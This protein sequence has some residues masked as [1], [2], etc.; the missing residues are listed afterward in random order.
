MC[1]SG[2][3]DRDYLDDRNNRNGLTADRGGPR[4]LY[5]VQESATAKKGG[6]I[7]ICKRELNSVDGRV[8]FAKGF[9]LDTIIVG[10]AT[11]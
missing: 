7:S 1:L 6:S 11:I 2:T 8:Y 5:T 9:V 10:A 4:K 3:R